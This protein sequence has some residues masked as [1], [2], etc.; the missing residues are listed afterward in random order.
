MPKWQIMMPLGMMLGLGLGLGLAFLLEL[1]DTSI[2]SPS[3]ISR[4]VDLPLL[5]MVPHT[6]DSG[7]IVRCLQDAAAHA[8]VQVR[9]HCGVRAVTRRVGGGFTLDLAGG[10]HAAADR[11]HREGESDQ[12]AEKCP[13]RLPVRAVDV[14]R[15][16][17][18]PT[19]PNRHA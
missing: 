13:R 14:D 17:H 2:K 4:R 16:A 1:M 12:R 18:G 9:T 19:L 11:V 15:S 5:G 7:T 6:D 10:G 8:G 3:D